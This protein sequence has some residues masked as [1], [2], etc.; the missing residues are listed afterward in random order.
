MAELV[1]QDSEL[2]HLYLN[3]QLPLAEIASRLG[4]SKQGVHYR[5]VR[6][7]VKMRPR[8]RKHESRIDLDKLR[9]L[10]LDRGLSLP[11]AAAE[12][13]VSRYAVVAA[14]NSL[15]IHS[16][17]YRCRVIPAL[18]TLKVGASITF[19]RRNAITDDCRRFY[20]FAQKLGIKLS[21]KIVDDLSI[22]VTRIE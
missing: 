14:A 12:L 11:M 2:E 1:A 21:I 6:A 4:V 9:H 19:R 16:K 3:E 8:S 5:L 7:G 10:L 17:K 18:N 15:G 20:G 13:G 22:S